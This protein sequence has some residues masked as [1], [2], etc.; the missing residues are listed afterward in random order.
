MKNRQPHVVMLSKRAVDIIRELDP[1]ELK[2]DD[3]VLALPERH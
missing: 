2:S 3:L 1:D